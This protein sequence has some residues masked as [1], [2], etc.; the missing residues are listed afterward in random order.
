MNLPYEQELNEWKEFLIGYKF[1][2]SEM[3]TKLEILNQEFELIHNYNPIEHIKS[4]MKSPQSIMK[5]LKRK[6][7]DITVENAQQNVRDIAGIRIS[8]SFTTDI[9]AIVDAL[10]KQDDIHIIEIKDYIK[11]PKSNGYRSLHLIT[12]IPVFFSNCKKWMP[13]EIQI[14]T[15]A[16]DF[17]ASLEH[18]IYYKFS[19]DVP[20]HLLQELKGS[21]DMI[22]EL[23]DKML[24]INEEVQ[25]YKDIDKLMSETKL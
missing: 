18:K 16:M 10:G 4:R 11:N 2:L 25:I 14:R 19:K 6:N 13:V 9:Y 24:R 12:E 21:A 20:E 7:L 23:D 22:A 3:N 5:K 8:C 1:A 17:W 15:I